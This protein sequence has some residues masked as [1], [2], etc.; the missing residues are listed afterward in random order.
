MFD[1]PRQKRERGSD[2]SINQHRRGAHA[3]KARTQSTFQ[4]IDGRRVALPY[5]TPPWSGDLLAPPSIRTQPLGYG[6]AWYGAAC[7]WRARRGWGMSAAVDTDATRSVRRDHR[8]KCLT[9]ANPAAAAATDP[10]ADPTAYLRRGKVH[11]CGM[12]G[13]RSR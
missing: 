10:A 3:R 2:A 12:G 11:G 13:W 7:D 8:F 9:S 5:R 1:K 6:A 4:T